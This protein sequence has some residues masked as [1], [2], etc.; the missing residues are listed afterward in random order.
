MECRMADITQ[1]SVRNQLRAKLSAE[2]FAY[3]APHLGQADLPF[4]PTVHSAGKV[5]TAVFFPERGYASMLAAL[6]VRTSSVLS[7][8]HEQS[9]PAA[10]GDGGRAIAM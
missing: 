2:D 5:I 6:D 1:S 3:L 10:E 7:S 4:R 8:V 9:E